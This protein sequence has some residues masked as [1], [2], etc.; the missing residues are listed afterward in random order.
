M[1]GGSQSKKPADNEKAAMQEEDKW[2]KRKIQ[3]NLIVISAAFM[4]LFTAFQSMA[5][6][7]S[8][9]NKARKKL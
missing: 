2:L 8:S 5:A 3:K 7:Q 4:V 9:L 6:L 1:A